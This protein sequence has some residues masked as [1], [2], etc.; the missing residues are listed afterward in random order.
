MIIKTLPILFVYKDSFFD[1]MLVFFANHFSN[2]MFINEFPCNL[3]HKII[4][5]YQPN[6]VLQEFWEGRIE[7][8]M[9][10]CKE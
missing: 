10:K 1:N 9:N 8:V 3:E 2:A 7:E 5:K 4:D 6:V